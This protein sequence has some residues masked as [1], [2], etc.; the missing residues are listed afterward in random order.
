MPYAVRCLRL[1]LAELTAAATRPQALPIWPLHMLK[2]NAAGHLVPNSGIA[3][4][5]SLYAGSA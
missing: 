1:R 2:I 4:L 5:Y 3:F